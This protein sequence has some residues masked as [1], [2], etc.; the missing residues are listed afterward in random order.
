VTEGFDTAVKPFVENLV[1]T[2]SERLLLTNLGWVVRSD[3][4]HKGNC[5]RRPILLQPRTAPSPRERTS[6]ADAE[7]HKIVRDTLGLHLGAKER[8]PIA[9]VAHKPDAERALMDQ[10]D[11]LRRMYDRR[12]GHEDDPR[13]NFE[14]LADRAIH[15]LN[16]GRPT[17]FGMP[18]ISTPEEILRSFFPGGGKTPAALA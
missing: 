18:R 17:E 14:Y 11:V 5:E 7:L 4:I 8:K 6:K 13:D 1:A 12:P 9:P 2:V 15:L 16:H 3:A 10:L